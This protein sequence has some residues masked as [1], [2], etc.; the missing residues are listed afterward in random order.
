MANAKR[1]RIIFLLLCL[2]GLSFLWTGSS[3]LSWT[4]RLQ[5]FYPAAQVDLFSEVIG[6]LF[7]AAGLFFYAWNEK[8]QLPSG[9][10]AQFILLTVIGFT[11]ACLARLSA[12]GPVVL[13]FGL[14][15]NL[16]FGMIAGC[17]LTFL[18]ERAPVNRAGL[19][20]GASYAF[21]SICSFLLSLPEEGRFLHAAAVF[22]GYAVMVAL[23]ILAAARGFPGGTNAPAFETSA[24]GRSD[25]PH[26]LLVIAGLAVFLLSC[27]NSAGTYFPISDVDASSVSLELSRAF[28]AVGLLVAGL[29]ND[30]KRAAGAVLCMAALCFP[31]F[32]ITA[33]G[34][35][36]IDVLLRILGYTFF[37]F[38]AV[39]RVILFIDFAQYRQLL[40]LAPLGLL[41][42]RLGD[43]AGTEIGILLKA[44]PI[45]LVSLIAALFVLCV[46]LFFYLFQNLYM[47]PAASAQERVQAF[48][49]RFD[50]SAR[51]AELVALVTNG[52]TN[53]EIAE[54]LFISEN[55]VKFHMRNLLKKTGCTNRSEV[56]HLFEETHR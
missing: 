27:I 25:Q 51:E 13:V 50:L 37:G 19:I 47:Q 24:P 39:Y 6:Y 43:A 32:T 12:S 7:Q 21:G 33:G 36:E 42:G 16:L 40:F 35:P 11:L 3:F 55:T 15:M 41:F 31:F 30:K 53:K 44:H 28:Y 9:R 54:S 10:S 56:I 23:V 29:V 1:N 38:Y 5:D 20:F 34:H 48:A 46:F 8:R 45:A 26:R 49:A 17:Y 52:L 2:I 22:A 4:Y 18:C 14:G